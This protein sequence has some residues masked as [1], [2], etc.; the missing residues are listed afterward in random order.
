MKRI[1]GW[2][3]AFAGEA[4]PVSAA[5]RMPVSECRLN[6]TFLVRLAK[7]LVALGDGANEPNGDD[8]GEQ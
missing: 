2:G 1:F 7:R 6:A 3:L 5:S 4:K 8:D